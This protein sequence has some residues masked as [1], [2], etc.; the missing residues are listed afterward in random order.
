MHT[1]I[2]IEIQFENRVLP[3][4][5]RNDCLRHP[6]KFRE[7][8]RVFRKVMMY[9]PTLKYTASNNGNVFPSNGCHKASTKLIVR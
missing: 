2:L 9:Y 6:L 7:I 4:V 1:N 8:M 3:C 5:F